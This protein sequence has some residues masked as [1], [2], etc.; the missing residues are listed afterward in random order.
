MVQRGHGA[1]F[2]FEARP[3]AGIVGQI[4]RQNL[5]GYFPAQ[6]RVL[7]AIHFP[8][9]AGAKPGNNFIR[10]QAGCWRQDI[11]SASI[12]QV[13]RA[14]GSLLRLQIVHRIRTGRE[15]AQAMLVAVVDHT[16]HLAAFGVGQI[17]GKGKTA[18]SF[19]NGD[20][21]PMREKLR[22]RTPKKQARWPRPSS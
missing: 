8:H 19:G 2:G 18:A 7:R 9:G 13:R 10:T 22:E 14:P 6:P 20:A 3:A 17:R 21:A 5:D 12:A 4:G 16:F 11:Y 1:G 15:G